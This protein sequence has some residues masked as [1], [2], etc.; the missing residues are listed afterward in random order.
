MIREN[1]FFLVAIDL[2]TLILARLRSL[3]HSVVYNN[4]GFFVFCSLTVGSALVFGGWIVL[5]PVGV[6]VIRNLPETI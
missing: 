5:L 1:R 4:L 6:F 2:S 3:H